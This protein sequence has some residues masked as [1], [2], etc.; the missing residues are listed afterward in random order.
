MQVPVSR[1][2]GGVRQEAVLSQQVLQILGALGNPVRREAHILDDQGGPFGT[3]LPD[4]AEEPVADPPGQLDLVLVASEFQGVDQVR[5]GD[6][7]GGAGFRGVEPGRAVRAELDQQRRG[8]GIQTAPV[9]RGAGEGLRGRGQRGGEH[10]LHRFGA[11]GDQAGDQ[12]GRFADRRQHDPGDRGGGRR[13]DGVDHGFG[14]ERERA[15]GSD[16]EPAEDL[17]RGI[18]VEQGRQRVAV[19]VADGE[20]MADPLRELLI[21]QQFR[22]QLQQPVGQVRLGGGERR[23]GARRGGVDDRARGEHQ[24]QRRHGVVGVAL[25]GAAHAAG[26]I[27]DD[28]ADRGHVGGGGVRPQPPPGAPQDG[29]GLAQDRSG[30]GPQPGSAVLDHHAGPVPPDV[31]EDVVGLRLPVQARAAGPERG[32]PPGPGAVRQDRA[33]VVDGAGQDDDLRQV[34]VGTGVGGVAD[35]V[36]NPVQHLVL[37]DQLDQVALQGRRGA[38]DAGGIDGIVL[39]RAAAGRWPARGA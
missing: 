14:H 27:G 5:A 23:L 26:V 22:A 32:V 15:L 10:E 24:G 33:H 25:Q 38:L 30:A 39:R 20:L 7:P 6:L 9:R 19:G 31:D 29:I 13:R 35:Q 4:D 8:G 16:D 1:V 21:G 18:G 11:L 28:S 34:P 2:P 36:R 37:A 12:R 3:P 17:Q